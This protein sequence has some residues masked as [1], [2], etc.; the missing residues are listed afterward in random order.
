M[1]SK[2]KNLVLFYLL[3]LALI[4]N[5]CKSKNNT[6]SEKGEINYNGVYISRDTLFSIDKQFPNE[7]TVSMIRFNKN[8]TVQTS[9]DYS[10][11]EHQPDNLTNANFLKWLHDFSGYQF[12]LKGKTKVNINCHSKHKRMWNDFATP[13]KTSVDVDFTIRGDTLFRNKKFST[14]FKKMYILD[15]NLT[16]NHAKIFHRNACEY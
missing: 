5:G 2:E 15:K 13:S 10:Y 11:I 7:I 4:C 12:E 16:N 3:F 6:K 1:L 14:D 8:Q 9:V